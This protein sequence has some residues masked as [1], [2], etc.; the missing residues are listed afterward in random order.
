MESEKEIKESLFPPYI[1]PPAASSS[2]QGRS[3]Q[4]MIFI[5][6]SNDITKVS[7]FLTN[8]NL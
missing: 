4:K 3:K 8:I 5:P 2:V 6:I 1:C 7:P